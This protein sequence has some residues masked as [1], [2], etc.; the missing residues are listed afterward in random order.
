MRCAR[1][2]AGLGSGLRAAGPGGNRGSRL[3][4]KEENP[5]GAPGARLP[6]VC[7][8]PAPGR[9]ERP[10]SALPRRRCEGGT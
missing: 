7:G 9:R 2:A 1:S 4:S 8:V 5:G 3:W 10:G 6:F